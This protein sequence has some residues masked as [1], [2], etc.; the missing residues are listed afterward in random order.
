MGPSST[1]LRKGPGLFAPA[2]SQTLMTCG[3]DMVRET[4]QSIVDVVPID[5]TDKQRELQRRLV[6]ALHEAL[7]IEACLEKAER[8][9]RS[10]YKTIA[11]LLID[12]RHEFRGPNLERY[13]LRGRSSGYRSAVREAYAQA[14]TD[15]DAPIPKR[16]TAGVAY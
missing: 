7:P 9:A 12:L 6:Q 14:G 16:L 13:D 3:G 4:E 15:I 11:E 8:Q 10:C 1:P 2:D 5:L